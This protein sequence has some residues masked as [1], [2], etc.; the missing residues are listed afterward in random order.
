MQSVE[1]DTSNAGAGETNPYPNRYVPI[2]PNGCICQWT[3]LKH[4]HLY[5]LLGPQG[6]AHDFVRVVVLKEPRARHGKTLFHLGDMLQF[7]DSMA[8]QQGTGFKRPLAARA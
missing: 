6:R 8:E 4:G 1:L 3:G 2:V 5:K 7:L